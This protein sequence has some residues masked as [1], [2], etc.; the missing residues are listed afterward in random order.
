MYINPP[1]QDAHRAKRG[2][3]GGY[4]ASEG[5]WAALATE[6]GGSPRLA[7]GIRKSAVNSRV[8]CRTGSVSMWALLR[9]ESRRIILKHLATR[10][11]FNETVLIS[12]YMFHCPSKSLKGR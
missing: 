12:S 2:V 1:G 7:V 5:S 3:E 10:H 6:G 8:L 4:G 9:E 11:L